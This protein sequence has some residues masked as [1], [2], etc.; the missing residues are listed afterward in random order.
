[1]SRFYK[2]AALVLIALLA[3]KAWSF[4]NTTET[5]QVL[6]MQQKFITGVAERDW[7]AIR[8]MLCSDYA[9]EWGHDVEAR[10]HEVFG[11]F[12]FLTIKPKIQRVQV[13]KGLAMIVTE[14][15]LEGNG[16]GLSG[17][18]VTQA[19]AVIKPWFFHWHKRGRWPWSWELVQVHN[20]GVAEP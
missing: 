7:G 16:A 12:F 14:L 10:M 6:A 8:G 5:E 15:K 1:M 11:Y 3:W 17:E 20:D 4:F 13:V 19:N 18:V 2:P 9:D